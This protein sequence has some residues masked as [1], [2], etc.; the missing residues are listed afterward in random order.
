[1]L[2]IS[3]ICKI[4]QVEWTYIH[5]AA[6]LISS[7]CSNVIIETKIASLLKFRINIVLSGLAHVLLE[8]CLQLTFLVNSCDRFFMGKYELLSM[9]M[10]IFV[11]AYIIKKSPLW[12]TDPGQVQTLVRILTF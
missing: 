3:N 7:S 1:M 11:C 8:H 2:E 5:D 6:M 10:M 4:I 12:E 9:M